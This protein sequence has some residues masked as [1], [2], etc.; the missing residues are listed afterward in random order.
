MISISR[1]PQH[2]DI[3]QDIL[4]QNWLV[5]SVHEHV[6][7]LVAQH[8]ANKLFCLSAASLPLLPFSA[9][10]PDFY[11]LSWEEPVI[12]FSPSGIFLNFS[13]AQRIDLSASFAPIHLKKQAIA[14]AMQQCR[15]YMT[16]SFFCSNEPKIIQ[17]NQQLNILPVYI[18]NNSMLAACR[19]V[20]KI[21]GLGAG[22]T[23]SGDDFLCGF[24]LALSLKPLLFKEF[25]GF[26]QNY[27]QTDFTE[28]TSL[29]SSYF[30]SYALKNI[31]AE[32]LCHIQKAILNDNPHAISQHIK[33]S[34][35]MGHTSGADTLLGL[36]TGLSAIA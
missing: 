8:N 25:T 34:A 30:L 33:H 32:N 2:M 11:N 3:Q 5:L 19:I 16:T 36:Y 27:L 18:L 21:I 35:Q 26:L 15:L 12:S 10:T 6:V 20:K 29:I 31:Y 4:E 9:Q 17:I 13:Q 23:P 22:L 1:L 28:Q 7:N 14:I 24:L